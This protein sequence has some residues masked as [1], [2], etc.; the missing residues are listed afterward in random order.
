MNTHFLSDTLVLLKRSL[1]HILRSP[2]TIITTAITVSRASAGWGLS[3]AMKVAIS[4]TSIMVTASVSS[5]VP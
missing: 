3:P 1:R 5:S 4:A 2:D